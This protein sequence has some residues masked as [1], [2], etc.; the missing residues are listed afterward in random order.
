MVKRVSAQARRRQEEFSRLAARAAREASG[1]E[2]TEEEIVQAV[3]SGRRTSDI[4]HGEETQEGGSEKASDP[5][6]RWRETEER[7]RA[8]RKIAQL[9]VEAVP[10]PDALSQELDT[11]YEL[12]DEND[13]SP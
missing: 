8:A 4:S 5:R 3:K 6:R 7:R 12:C 13:G 11:T 10:E 1:P 9:T 2:P